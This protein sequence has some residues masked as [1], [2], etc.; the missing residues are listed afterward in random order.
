MTYASGLDK[1]F[2]I[3]SGWPPAIMQCI[4]ME[5]EDEGRWALVP[6][7]RNEIVCVLASDMFCHNPNP[8]YEFCWK[9]AK[10]LV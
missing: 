4:N 2:T 1:G 3:P 10:M 7:V 9:K 5:N 8:N 6:S